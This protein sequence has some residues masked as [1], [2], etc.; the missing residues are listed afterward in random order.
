M[1]KYTIELRKVIDTLGEDEVKS[2]FMNYDLHDYL[3]DEE[4]AVVEKRGTFSKE[5]LAKKIL[6]H[7]YMHEIGLETVALFKHYAKM[8]MDEIME[9]KLPLIYSAAI[10]Y[11]PLVNIDFV[12]EYSATNSGSSNDMSATSGNGLSIQSDTPQGK[13]NKASIL[14][15]DYASSTNGNETTSQGQSQSSTEESQEYT[16]KTRG[17]SGSLSTSQKLIQQYRENIIMIERDIIKDLGSLFMI[18][19]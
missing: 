15:G 18:I 2:W 16:R 1:S 6:N 4:I 7:Y 13:I 14:A 3:T 19:Y 5:K 9:S 10:E 17:N 8:A 11:D 12:E